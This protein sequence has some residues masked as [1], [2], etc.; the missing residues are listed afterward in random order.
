MESVSK[1]NKPLT[2][3]ILLRCSEC[4]YHFVKDS[5]EHNRCHYVAGN[6]ICGDC[7][8]TGCW[9]DMCDDKNEKN[10]INKY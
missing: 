5:Q 6:L 1:I 8:E 4:D 9:C 2:L 7:V 3:P 10:Q